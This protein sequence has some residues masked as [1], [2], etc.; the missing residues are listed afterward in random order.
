[1]FLAFAVIWFNQTRQNI[2]LRKNKEVSPVSMSA[3]KLILGEVLNIADFAMEW[4]LSLREWMVTHCSVLPYGF[5][6]VMFPAL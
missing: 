1:M 5:V 4:V 6:A 3:W 2:P